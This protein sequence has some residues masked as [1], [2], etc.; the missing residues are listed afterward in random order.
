MNAALHWNMA[1]RIFL[2]AVANMTFGLTACQKSDKPPSHDASLHRGMAGEP[3]SLDPVL[4][5]DTFSHE[6][7]MDLYEG[8]T[9]DAPNGDVMPGVASSWTVDK[10][11]TTYIFNLRPNARWSNGEAVTAGDFV[12]AWRRVLNPNNGSPVADNLRLIAGAAAIINGVAD[13]STLGAY[14]VTDSVLKV[15]LEQ[16]APYFPEILTDSAAYPTFARGNFS[17]GKSS[18]RVFNGPYALK[19]WSPGTKMRLRKN[20]YYW[21]NMHVRI[22]EI[23]YQF[24]DENAQYARYRAGQL[25]MTDLVPANAIPAIRKQSSSELV[26]SPFLATAYYGLNLLNKPFANNIKLRQ[27]LAMAIDRE[28]LVNSLAF[29]QRPAYGFVPPGTW[30]YGPQTW[31]WAQLSDADR[32][33]KAKQLYEEAGY[34]KENPLSIRLLFNSDP[35]IK[36]TAII[37]AEMWK[38]TLGIKSELNAEEYRVFLQSRRDHSKWEVARLGWTADFND[39]SNFLDIFRSNSANNDTSYS[40]PEFDALINKASANINPE[41]RRREL[42][43]GERMMLSDYPII[44]LYFFVSKRLVKPYVEGM[45]ANPLNRVGSKTLT[46]AAH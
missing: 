7:L 6:V 46:F 10:L 18:P 37:I 38:E 33:A 29:G 31:S 23:E 39:A 44:P 15:N 43:A 42:E 1:Y 2:I 41:D 35:V 32:T 40:N 24:A 8:L 19:D 11:G 14:A 45:Q 30:N 28:R 4:A 27:A 5:A 26:V 20:N 16:P 22:P 12:A 13:P 25:D 17:P 36:K 34:T 9:S 21:D 3:S